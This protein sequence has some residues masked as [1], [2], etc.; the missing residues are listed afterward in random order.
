MASATRALAGIDDKLELLNG[1]RELARS[2][3]VRSATSETMRSTRVEAAAMSKGMQRRRRA[4][5]P[6]LLVLRTIGCALGGK[7][8]NE[9]ENS[10][11]APIDLEGLRGRI[12]VVEASEPRH[13][14]D[15]VESFAD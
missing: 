12:L 7:D 8:A 13:R 10:N 11:G 3:G 15:D 2:S 5:D 4:V 14:P 6:R 1:L 9:G